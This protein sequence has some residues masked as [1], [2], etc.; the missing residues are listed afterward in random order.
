MDMK[1]RAKKKQEREEQEIKRRSMSIVSDN[2]YRASPISFVTASGGGDGAGG[3]GSAAAIMKYLKSEKP[4]PTSPN[5]DVTRL[6]PRTPSRSPSF[7]IRSQVHHTFSS[8]CE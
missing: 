8:Q 1:L 6:R 2:P 7:L 4:T 3:G 5:E